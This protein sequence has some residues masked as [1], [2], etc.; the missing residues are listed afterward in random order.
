M[1]RQQKHQNRYFL[2]IFCTLQ[3]LLLLT[4]FIHHNMY[5]WE[6]DACLKSVVGRFWRTINNPRESCDF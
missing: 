4:T 2:F 1:A 5:C 3:K 6:G